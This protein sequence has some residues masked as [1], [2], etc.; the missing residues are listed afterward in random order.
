MEEASFANRI[1]RAE[2]D[3]ELLEQLYREA[4]AR[5]E[6]TSFRSAM[7]S[8]AQRYSDNVLFTAWRCRLTADETFA[9]RNGRATHKRKWSAAV[10]LGLAAGAVLWSISSEDLTVDGEW[11]YFVLLWSPIV[12][13]AVIA[14]L[15]LAGKS[16]LRR[17]GYAVL[18]L[19]ATAA[20]A[21]VI[22]PT[23]EE[24]VREHYL[25]LSALHLPL[26]AFVAVGT[27]LLG[28]RYDALARFAYLNRSLEVFVT[29]GLFGVATVIFGGISVGLFQSLGVTFPEWAGRLALSVAGGLVPLLA[30]AAAYDPEYPPEEQDSGQ[31]LSR[32]VATLM[33][34]LLP[35]SCA[36]LVVYLAYIPF[37]FLEPFE[38]REV[39]I[40]YNAMLFA[41]MAL[42][43]GAIP[44]ARNDLSER[45]QV[46]LRR[47]VVSLSC[48]AVAVSL[49]ALAAIVYRTAAGGIT[50][51]RLTVIGW[52]TVNV[53]IL[54]SLIVRQV[55]ASREVW[56][57]ALHSAFGDA[58]YGYVGWALFVVVIIPLLFG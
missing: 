29:A 40:V 43:V 24:T 26:L 6:L 32:L 8:T 51:N 19:A 1:L 31:G 18:T 37:S 15:L 2:N 4:V 58:A 25:Q 22:A 28:L 17:A 53:L 47:G 10:T 42:L 46:L 27:T 56:L 30:L 20:Y 33:R 12:A 49:Y 3:P 41:I 57:E 9:V 7:L 14:F 36:V 45:V 34:I 11:P 38:N 5:N 13:V 52:N 39:L 23:L 44:V 35:M 48:L 50:V 54:V 16:A 55:R 21:V